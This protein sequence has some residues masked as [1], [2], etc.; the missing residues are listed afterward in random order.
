MKFRNSWPCR[1][2]NITRPI[3]N[4]ENLPPQT[5]E[6]DVTTRSKSTLN[7]KWYRLFLKKFIFIIIVV[8]SK[9]VRKYIDST[10]DQ[11]KKKKQK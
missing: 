10:K 7:K 5:A 9:N 2:V 8:F 4:N 3:P 11:I 6:L 1:Q